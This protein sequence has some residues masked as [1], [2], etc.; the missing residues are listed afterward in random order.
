[1]ARAQ[2]K[3]VTICELQAFKR[4]QTGRLDPEDPRHFQGRDAEELAK[5]TGER[6]AETRDGVLVIARTGDPA[7]GDFDEPVVVLRK[8]DLPPELDDLPF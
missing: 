4:N 3:R 8:G 5:R 1:M 6:L 2:A 7:T